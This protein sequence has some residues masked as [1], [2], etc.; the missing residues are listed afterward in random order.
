M[1]GPVLV[2]IEAFGSCLL[3]SVIE[4]LRYLRGKRGPR[5]WEVRY[6][7]PPL[8][9]VATVLIAL[10]YD[11]ASAAAS[12]GPPA[13]VG[14]SVFFVVMCG[15]LAFEIGRFVALPHAAGIYRSD[16]PRRPGRTSR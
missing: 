13:V 2:L 8:V 15:W 5:S 16:R 7:V 3:M 14:F 10:T 6:L 9:V 4:W 11:P 12:I 1:V